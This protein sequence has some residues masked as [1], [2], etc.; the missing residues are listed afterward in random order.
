MDNN[1]TTVTAK[2][3]VAVLLSHVLENHTDMTYGDLSRAIV[4]TFH[5]GVP[6]WH[7]MSKSLGEIEEA[8]KTLNLPSLPVMV[9]DEATKRPAK[10][11]YD[12]FDAL[13]PDLAGLTSNKKRDTAKEKV[14]SCSD[15]SKLYNYYNSDEVTPSPQATE[16]LKFQR[17]VEGAKT[18]SEQLSLEAAKNMSARK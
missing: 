15:W 10:I 3:I 8:C 18:S 9:I 6:M 12:K 2:E 17:Y 1:K 13:Y 14:L 11:W 4:Q 16:D 5:H 7:I